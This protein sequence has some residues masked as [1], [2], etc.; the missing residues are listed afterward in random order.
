MDQR[1]F[2]FLR[3]ERNPALQESDYAVEQRDQIMEQ[4]GVSRG[5]AEPHRFASH[6]AQSLATENQP[7]NEPDPERREDGLGRIFAHVLLAIFLES[8]GTFARVFPNLL[9]FVAIF[10][11]HRPRRGLQIARHYAGRRAKIVSRLPDMGFAAF[12]FVLGRGR[13][14]PAVA[15]RRSFV[16]FSH[17]IFL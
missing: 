12:E 9:G 1:R 7:E 15:L 4:A 11:G 6:A 10:F 16:F 17:D 8:A 5:I 2:G 3:E 14:R 13:D